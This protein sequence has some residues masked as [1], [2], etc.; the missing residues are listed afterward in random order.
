[1]AEYFVPKDISG[2]KIEETKEGGFI[3]I[4]KG[5]DESKL[6]IPCSDKERAEQ[7]IEMIGEV[8]GGGW[9]NA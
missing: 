2:M 6:H 8:G 3:L 7:I 9:I 1:M 5:A 4:I